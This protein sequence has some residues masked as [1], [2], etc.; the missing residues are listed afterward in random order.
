MYLVTSQTMI[1]KYLINLVK[2]IYIATLLSLI[3][4]RDVNYKNQNGS[5][6]FKGIRAK[7]KR[8]SNVQSSMK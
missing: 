3:F 1:A 2:E 4:P 8:F 5:I 6:P 7:M